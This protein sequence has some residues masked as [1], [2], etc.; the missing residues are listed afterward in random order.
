MEMLRQLE[1]RSVEIV[2]IDLAQTAR[3]VAAGLGAS[4][5]VVI[6]IPE[7]TVAT[8]RSLIVEI[9]T[10]MLDQAL[11]SSTGPSPVTVCA[12]SD[13]SG[14]RLWIGADGVHLARAVREGVR[15]RVEFTSAERQ[16]G[17]SA[18]AA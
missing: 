13:K 2:E 18:T 15:G 1:P 11:R 3:G 17:S 14:L 12:D 6:D 9:L 16:E 7:G 10:D 8:D 4:D 5:R